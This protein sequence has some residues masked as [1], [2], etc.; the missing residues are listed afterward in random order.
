MITVISF[1]Y[2]HAEPPT[3]HATYD[4]R[5]HFRDP[6]ITPGLR[7]LTAA[8][9]RVIDAVLTTPGI[10]DLI[11]SITGTIRAYLAGPATA[12]LTV[13]VG[14]VGGRH[15]SAVVAARVTQLVGAELV[16][17]D[18]HRPVLNR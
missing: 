14:C 1:G 2:G 8:D 11:D 6:H 7:D 16:H 13:A 15:R 9:R 4:L 17:R 3:A 12:P 5:E 18:I 10:T